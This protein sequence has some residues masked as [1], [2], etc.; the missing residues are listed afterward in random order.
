M[1]IVLVS[2]LHLMKVNGDLGCWLWAWK[3]QKNIIK[4]VVFYF[5]CLMIYICLM[6]TQI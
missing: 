4:V 3:C 6:K 2:L 5:R 1:F